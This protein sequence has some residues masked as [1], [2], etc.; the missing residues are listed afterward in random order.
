MNVSA[1]PRLGVARRRPRL[2]NERPV[3]GLQKQELTHGLV[4][5]LAHGAVG[6]A[7]ISHQPGGIASGVVNVPPGPGS[8]VAHPHLSVSAGAPRARARRRLD[9][10]RVALEVVPK[11]DGLHFTAPFVE[12]PIDRLEE[13][14]PFE[15]PVAVELGVVGR[16]D[17]GRYGHPQREL[18]ELSLALADE[19]ARVLEGLRARNAGLIRLFLD[20]GPRDAEVLE[21]RHQP[22]A[23]A[24]DLAHEVRR[25]QVKAD[26]AVKVAIISVAW[27][28]LVA[29]P[30]LPT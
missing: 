4:Q 27:V 6:L 28:T 2:Q 19:V 10:N 16:D 21:A 23:V 3:A 11:R 12:P 20:V 5:R 18:A 7:V 13:D 26:V 17:D 29:R 8:L 25:R 15:P 9:R 22:R 24:R 30:H 14:G 1:N